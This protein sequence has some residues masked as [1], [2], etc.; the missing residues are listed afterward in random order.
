MDI[1]RDYRKWLSSCLIDSDLSCTGSYH[2]DLID[3]S[4]FLSETSSRKPEPICFP[5]ICSDPRTWTR[6]TE[7]RQKVEK[8]F[9][10]KSSA[11]TA[12]SVIRNQTQLELRVGESA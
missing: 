1:K 4:S 2:F 6:T 7:T 5:N 10:T 11:P 3:I 12:E 8:V 9:K